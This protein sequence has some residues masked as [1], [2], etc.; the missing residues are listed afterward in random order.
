[1]YMKKSSQNYNSKRISTLIFSVS[2]ISVAVTVAAFSILN[3]GR[4]SAQTIFPGIGATSFPGE[5]TGPIPDAGAGCGN[6]AAT[7]RDVVFSVSGLPGRLS[8]VEVKA[9]ILHT[10]IGDLTATLIAPGGEQHILFSN[11]GGVPSFICGDGSD[12]IGNYTFKDTASGTNWWTAAFDNVN[13]IPTGEYR[14]TEAGP[15][16]SAETSPV[17]ELSAAFQGINSPNGI[18]TLR[19]NDA[20]GGD[21]GSVESAQLTLTTTIQPS[22][23]ILDFDGDSKTDVSVF[24]PNPTTFA[25]NVGPS[26]S[27]SQWWIFNSATET[28]LGITFGSN[29]DVPVPADYTGDGKT[30]VAFFRPSTSEWYVLRSED[31]TFFAFPFGAAN[32]VPVSG[33]FDG[34]GVSDPAVYRPSQGTWFIFRSSDS[35][36][37]AVPFGIAEDKP[38]IADFDGDGRDDIAVYR[39][40]AQQWWQLR[41]TLGVIGYQFGSPEDKTVV[42]DY[43]GDGLAD[44]AFYRPSTS[45]WFVIRSEDASFF[46]FPW[47][48]PGDLPVPGDYDGDSVADAAVWRAS[49]STWYIDGS[50]SGFEAV[51]FGLMTD[52]PLPNYVVMPQP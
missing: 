52:R 11:T 38:T 42:G 49:D 19:V 18:W 47:G 21:T 10:W 45:E 14:T 51:L 34:D 32:D 29:T 7:S 27:S 39:P 4:V 41:S 1:M 2:V 23:P 15:M 30:D 9:N 16:A 33:D 35:G 17:T 43:T 6:P 8:T 40:S 24:R 36:V 22:S 46:A 48:S 31:M 13:S 50:T 25:D 28:P 20:N 3:T 37:S 12:L 5:N 44:V 26:G